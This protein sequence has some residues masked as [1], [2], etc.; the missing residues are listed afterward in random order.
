MPTTIIIPHTVMST[1]MAP[2]T[3]GVAASQM[4]AISA[5]AWKIATATKLWRKL[6]KSRVST[7]RTGRSAVAG[8]VGAFCCG[9]GITIPA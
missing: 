3:A 9:K 6:L 4:K 8:I 5:V 7:Y 2:T 1:P